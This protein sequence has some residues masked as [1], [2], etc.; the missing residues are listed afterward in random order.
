MRGQAILQLVSSSEAFKM[1]ASQKEWLDAQNEKP[2]R[3][4]MLSPVD[5]ASSIE[6]CFESALP[7]RKPSVPLSQMLSL[8]GL[9][10]NVS[11]ISSQSNSFNHGSNAVL[12]CVLDEKELGG[13][14]RAIGKHTPKQ[15]IDKIE[16][17][18]SRKA[19][20]KVLY[21]SS[22]QDA[23]DALNKYMAASQ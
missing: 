17:G 16:K 23:L 5:V 21:F 2:E 9:P 7:A 15:G 11:G 19:T 1:G 22:P 10:S 8:Y 20:E 12:P 18:P 4:P 6:A 3:Q 13:R 14:R